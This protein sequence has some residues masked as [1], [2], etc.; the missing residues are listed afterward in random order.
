MD[1]ETIAINGQAFRFVK[2]SRRGDV[3]AVDTSGDLYAR[4]GEREA[5][6]RML[7]KLFKREYLKKY[8]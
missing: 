3:V 5:L 2:R 8:P 4:V 6:E 7:Y 1:Q